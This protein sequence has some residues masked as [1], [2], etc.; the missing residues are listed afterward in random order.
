MKA[1]THLEKIHEAIAKGEELPRTAMRLSGNKPVVADE[2]YA[3][4][5]NQ[6]TLDVQGFLKDS[7]WMPA[8]EKVAGFLDETQEPLDADAT[9]KIWTFKDE[10][11]VANFDAHVRAQLS[12]YDPL[13][14]Y[15]ADMASSFLPRN[16]VLYDIGA[17]TGSM[18]RLMQKDI[19]GKNVTAISIEPSA[20]MAAAF[21]GTGDLLVTD[22]EKVNF[23]H[24]P[25][26]VAILFLSMMFL[27]PAHR[28]KFIRKLAK[29]MKPGG[30]IIIVDKG[31]M[32][33]PEIQVACRNALMASKRDNGQDGNAWVVKELSL[34]GEQRPTD[35]SRIVYA[36]E[37]HDFVS[38]EFFR[39][40]EF[41]GLASVKHHL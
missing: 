9:P 29:A 1:K 31:Y 8:G 25:A 16:G 7:D 33:V 10:K 39:F 34:R 35:S 22:A 19:E 14:R 38:E 20:E 4:A 41:Y 30:V 23:S 11:V 15:V 32:H 12:W 2:M 28:D 24:A 36:L 5:D 37:G 40:G 17:S 21:K 27:K 6:L 3:D 13:S 26:D 18:T